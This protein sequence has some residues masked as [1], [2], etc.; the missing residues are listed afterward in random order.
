M[1][2]PYRGSSQPPRSN[3][4]QNYSRQNNQQLAP[5]NM[6]SEFDSMSNKM[7]QHMDR[8]LANLGF[9]S[10][11]KG[12]DDLENEMME[13]SNVHRHMAGLNQ[14]DVNQHSKD[15]VFQVYSSSYVQSSK[16]GPDGRVVQEKYFDNNAVAR[17]V[18]G[19][20]IS[21]R[22]QGYKNSDGID[23]FGHER[24]MNDKGRKHVRERDRTGQITTTN[25]YLNMDENQVEQF[26]NEW[27][28]MGR[29]LG[30]Q[31]PSGGLRALQGQQN[32]RD[33]NNH[34]FPKEQIA[35]GTPSYPRNNDIQPIMLGNNSNS[36]NNNPG[37]QALPQQQQQITRSAIQ[38]P[39]IQS[40]V[41]PQ[42]QPVRALPARKQEFTGVYQ[43]KGARNQHPQA[44]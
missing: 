12:F 21:E 41:P 42:Q 38:Q 26:E 10:V 14:R 22:Q 30:I 29:N 2:Q 43:N 31:G 13:F 25:H 19:H 34:P 8:Q 35:Y 3:Q 36:Y 15:G 4:I 20:T 18:N 1:L 17:G 16:M 24:M 5:F 40:R 9:G 7:M 11:F 6:F 37:R 44:G 23:R 27:L 39:G 28:G 32:M 33:L